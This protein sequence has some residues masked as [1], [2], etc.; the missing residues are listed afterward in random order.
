MT[1]ETTN[2]GAHRAPLHKLPAARKIDTGE[3]RVKRA[4]EN[5]CEAMHLQKIKRTPVGQITQK[6]KGLRLVQEKSV[7]HARQQIDREGDNEIDFCPKE[8]ANNS[9]WSRPKPVDQHEEDDSDDDAGMGD[10]EADETQI[11]KTESQIR[12]D[13]GLERAA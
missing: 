4:E 12:R 7:I 5:K 11:R 2:I 8:R 13:D 9:D 6:R 10:E 1:A 3:G